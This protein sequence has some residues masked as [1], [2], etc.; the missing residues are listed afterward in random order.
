MKRETLTVLNDLRRQGRAVVRA[1][2]LATGDETLV[3]PHT[4]KTAVGLAAADAARADTSA[5]V[6]ID[7]RTWFLE[8]Y[9]PPLDL[10]I[11]GAVHIAQPLSQMA[12]IAGYGVRVIDPRT[13]FATAERFPGIALSHDWADEALAKAPLG[14]R[15]AVVLLTHDP[16]LDDPALVVALKSNCFYIGALGSKK[17]QAA[18]RARMKAEGFGDIELARIRGP[19]GLNIGARSPAEIAVSILAEVTLTLRGSK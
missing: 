16:K 17:T 12:A 15:S 3:D 9:N 19:I 4:D 8:V 5:N 2:D 13:A 1:V 7:G 6:E 10:V 18:R 14:P 11:V